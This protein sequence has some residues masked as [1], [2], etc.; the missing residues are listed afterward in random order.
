MVNRGGH[1][2]KN[3]FAKWGQMFSGVSCG[4]D[5]LASIFISIGSMGSCVKNTQGEGARRARVPL[6]T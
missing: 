4:A 6:E 1:A 2:A 3:R 5:G